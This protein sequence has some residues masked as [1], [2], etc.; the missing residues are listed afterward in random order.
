MEKKAGPNNQ[1]EEI[2]AW[3]K[4]L[5]KE[6]MLKLPF[7]K[8]VFE[9]IENKFLLV[10]ATCYQL[11]KK[12]L[13]G[14][15]EQGKWI[16]PDKTAAEQCSPEWIAR[17]RPSILPKK[18]ETWIDAT[19]GLGIDALF[20]SSV[21]SN[22]LS[23]ETEPERAKCLI[24]N[25]LEYSISNF[26]VEEKSILNF[27]E[28]NPNFLN[29]SVL[30]YADPDRRPEKEEKRMF[31]WKDSSP[32][33]E[34]LYQRVRLQKAALLVKLSPMEDLDQ[35]LQTFPMASCSWVTSIQNEVKEVLVYWSPEWK[36]WAHKRFALDI[37]NPDDFQMV[38]LPSETKP[39]S[40]SKPEP[41]HFI[42]DPL[43]AIRKGFQSFGWA[44][45]QGFSCLSQK[46]QLF[47][48]PEF[49]PDFPGRVFEIEAVFSELKPALAHS[50]NKP[51]QVVARSYPEKA[52]DLQKKIG[53]KGSEKHFLFAF[54]TTDGKKKFI[55][56]SRIR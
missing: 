17:L 32:N 39:V 47:Q 9:G 42:L 27:L 41:G 14:I 26:K 12:K 3:C 25:F 51:L 50:G 52:E 33:L 18:F 6:K 31:S 10:Q 56:A 29:P 40:E 15:W 30:V 44:E 2:L 43:A 19:A 11:A 1:R 13:P 5:S 55:L 4:A 36:E 49:L 7:Q 23:F 35:V 21:A 34:E 28:E 38:E 48:S 54:Q 46:G 37:R 20:A 16:F 22:G 24:D 53:G 45:K 8:P